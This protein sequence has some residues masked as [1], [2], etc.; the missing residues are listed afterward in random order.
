MKVHLFN[1]QKTLSINPLL[2]KKAV[3]FFL[4][5]SGV[6][7][8]EVALYFVEKK[9]IQRLHE[10]Y[11]KD[12]TSTDCLSFPLDSPKEKGFLGE[13]F[14]CPKVA[15]EYAEKHNVNPYD[16]TLLYVIHSLLHLMG[17]K[18]SPQKERIRMQKKEKAGM[19]LL[20]KNLLG[21]S[22]TQLKTWQ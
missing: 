15:L 2:T 9:E 19:K 3:A 1:H 21:L 17:F 4:K 12:P 10:K 18:D 16:E 7:S 13:V 6:K 14:I 20:K 22:K 5:K 8:Q 11:F